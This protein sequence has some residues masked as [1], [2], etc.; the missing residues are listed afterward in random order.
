MLTGTLR[1]PAR[2]ADDAGDE[3]L[4]SHLVEIAFVDAFACLPPVGGILPLSLPGTSRRIWHRV[5]PLR[6]ELLPAALRYEAMKRGDSTRQRRQRGTES[7]ECVRA[8]ARSVASHLHRLLSL[9]TID[10]LTPL[11][12]CQRL[13]VGR[14]PS[15]VL[16]HQVLVL[17]R[18][19]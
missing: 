5:L 8:A 10:S 4:G 9:P 2:T 11:P 16:R 12:G 1:E 18:S 3:L 14:S 17:A 19:S 7:S 6:A 13:G 15:A